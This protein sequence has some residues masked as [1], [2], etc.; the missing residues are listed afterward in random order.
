MSVCELL[1]RRQLKAMNLKLLKQRIKLSHHNPIAVMD[2]WRLNKQIEAKA[3]FGGDPEHPAITSLNSAAKQGE[4]LCNYTYVI[5]Y[6]RNYTELKRVCN[7]VM[8]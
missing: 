8:T 2:V 6:S 3:V 4:Q 5:T 7:C 1:S